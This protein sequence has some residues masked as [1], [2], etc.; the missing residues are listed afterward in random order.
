MRWRGGRR[1]TVPPIEAR[2]CQNAPLARMRRCLPVR[3]RT[4][5]RATHRQT[6]TGEKPEML[7]YNMDTP[8]SELFAALPPINAPL[9]SD[10]APGP[11]LTEAEWKYVACEFGN[12]PDYV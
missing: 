6:Q 5:L 11:Y 12:S 9:G 3:I 8:L 4:C 10:T 1:P 2:L 7:M